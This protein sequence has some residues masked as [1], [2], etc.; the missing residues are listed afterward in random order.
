ME[1]QPAAAQAG[2]G[3][4]GAGAE[5]VFAQAT[6][7][8]ALRAGADAGLQAECRCLQSTLEGAGGRVLRK[9]DAGTVR[10]TRAAA[11]PG[12][13]PT[14]ICL[15]V[16]PVAASTRARARESFGPAAVSGVVPDA[17]SSCGQQ[18]K[19]IVATRD[20]RDLRQDPDRAQVVAA[21]A[22][23]AVAVSAAWVRGCIEA[24]QLLA[25]VYEDL[26]TTLPR[27]SVVDNRH[28][29][30][31]VVTTLSMVPTAERARLHELI[32]RHGGVVGS[33][34]TAASTPLVCGALTGAQVRGALGMPAVHI[35]PP[36]WV[37]NSIRLGVRENEALHR[38]QLAMEAT[39]EEAPDMTVLK[40]Y[41]SSVF[42]DQA[43]FVAECP[44]AVEIKD[45]VT[46]L[47]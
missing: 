25:C 21:A 8:L 27:W 37:T 18:V 11:R 20:V 7:F 38:P 34:R 36:C 39:L 13:A 2:G 43:F 6:F 24:R 31:G 9:L 15:R 47:P 33:A 40:G 30:A 29:F 46:A 17:T 44:A 14:S 1:R 26:R 42:E 16:T 45:Q 5:G 19:Y 12:Q 41:R 32:T 28:C 23:G 35:V 10:G 4:T 22:R 3:R